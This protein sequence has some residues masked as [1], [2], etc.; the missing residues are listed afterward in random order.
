GLKDT[1]IRARSGPRASLGFLRSHIVMALERLRGVPLGVQTTRESKPGEDAGF[2]ACDCAYVI[3]RKGEDEQSHGVPDAVGRIAGVDGERG[4]AV[5]L[6]RQD[7][8]WGAALAHDRGE[9]LGGEAAALPLGW[10]GGHG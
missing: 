7:A 9:E 6:G 10:E 3:S 1:M 5:R 8:V 2:E 4:L